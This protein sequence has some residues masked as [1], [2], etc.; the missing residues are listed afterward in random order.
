MKD[1]EKIE[2]LGSLVNCKYLDENNQ[3]S[4][5]DID[6]LE[7]LERQG[8]NCNE[9]VEYSDEELISDNKL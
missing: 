2:P 3:C 4:N 7:C 6:S 1:W 9:K 8:Q 5:D